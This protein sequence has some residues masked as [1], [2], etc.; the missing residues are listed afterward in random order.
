M[1]F[2][3]LSH[4]DEEDIFSLVVVVRLDSIFIADDPLQSAMS[5]NLYFFFFLLSV[6]FYAM[7]T[8]L[9]KTRSI[10]NLL[11]LFIGFFVC[12]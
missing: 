2:D 10:I 8:L 6:Y 3:V 5:S 1:F 7:I 4:R 11:F 12:L 9:L